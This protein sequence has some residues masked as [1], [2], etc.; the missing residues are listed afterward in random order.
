MRTRRKVVLLALCLA[1]LALAVVL[2]IPSRGP[3]Y[4]GRSLSHWVVV[5]TGEDGEKEADKGTAAVIQA[6]TNAVPYLL[7]WIQFEHKPWRD[8]VADQ[9]QPFLPATADDIRQ[10]ERER[11]AA[12]TMNAFEVLGSNAASSIPELT[13][14]MN[15]PLA[16]ETAVRATRALGL[17]GTNALPALLGVVDNPTHPCRVVALESLGYMRSA[18]GDSAAMLVPHL[19][20]CLNDQNDPDVAVQATFTLAFFRQSPE[21]AV[22]ALAKCLSSTNQ[23]LQEAS[24]HAL[25]RFGR[26]ASAAVPALEAE[27]RAPGSRINLTASN[28]LYRIAPEVMTNA[29]AK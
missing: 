15:D 10:S 28:A 20:N 12:A 13:R 9:L 19:I 6:G 4:E 11:L 22:P 29:P 26:A 23:E 25:A 24:A 1:A 17:S 3:R 21:L 5:L 8:K 7:K 18:L 2:I 16:P 14:L 27:Y